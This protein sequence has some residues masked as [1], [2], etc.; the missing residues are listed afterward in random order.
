MVHDV[1]QV[2]AFE[3]PTG[4]VALSGGEGTKV[5]LARVLRNEQGIKGTAE[6]TG[7]EARKDV[8]GGRHLVGRGVQ[9]Y[10]RGEG[11]RSTT[12]VLHHCPESGEVGGLVLRIG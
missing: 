6:E 9:A 5:R 8:V 4:L 1:Q 11:A 12:K 10:R 2:A 3:Q 7:E